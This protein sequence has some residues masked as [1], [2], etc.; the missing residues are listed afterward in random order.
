MA[1]WRSGDGTLEVKGGEKALQGGC[2][3]YASA[4]FLLLFPAGELLVPCRETPR[5]AVGKLHLPVRLASETRYYR[6]AHPVPCFFAS[7]R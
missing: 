2:F 5:K 3:C 6:P 1:H 4:A 7:V